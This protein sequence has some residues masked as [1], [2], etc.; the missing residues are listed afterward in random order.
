MT[1]TI[2]KNCEYCGNP[3]DAP[4]SEVNRGNGKFCTRSCGASYRN[5]HNRKLNRL[6]KPIEW[7][8]NI[9]YL[10]GL[11]TSDGS[12]DRDRKRLKVTNSDFEIIEH[13]SDIVKN[14]IT[15]RTYKPT[16]SVKGDS[17]WWNYQFT[18]HVFYD[19]CKEIG[20]MPNKSL[21]LE[22]VNVPKKYYSHFLRGLIDG[23]GNYS[24][25]KRKYI[26]INIHSG[27]KK[28]LDNVLEKCK[29]IYPVVGGSVYMKE[30]W[31]ALSIAYQD[32]LKLLPHIYKDDFYSLSRKKQIVLPYIK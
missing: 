2:V 19:F 27:S 18:S 28:F 14:E 32:S 1:K 25:V 30:E 6:E 4:L 13:T 11:I 23:D 20:L 17:V 21:I 29:N 8:N 31:Y 12:L 5:Q 7:S 16:E 24:H 15:G 22:E 26:N 10:I 3:F 9:A